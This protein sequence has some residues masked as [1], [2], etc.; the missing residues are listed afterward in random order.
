MAFSGDVAEPATSKA[1]KVSLADEAGAEIDD[2]NPL[3]VAIISGGSGGV[4]YTEGDTDATII[5]NAILWEDAAN[6]LVVVSASKPLPV[7]LGTNNDV[8]ITSGTVTANAGTNLNTSLL[9]LET[10]G[11]LTT[12]A[13]KD[14]ATQTTLSAIN[15]KMVSG[16]DIGDVTINNS[17]GVSAVNIQDGGNVITI[18]GTLTSVATITNVVHVDDNS[19]SIS[20]DDGAGAIT[21]DNA[22]TFAVQATLSAETTKVIGTVNQGT[23]PW[24]VSGAVTNAVLSVVG[25]G[26]EATAQ[27]VTIATDSTG[28]LSIDDNGSSITVDG[29]VAL[30]VSQISASCETGTVYQGTTAKTPATLFANVAASQTDSVLLAAQGASNKIRVLQVA[31]VAGSTATNLTFNSKGAGAGTA[32]SPL[33]ANAANGGEVLPFSPVGWFDTVANEALTVTTG[34]GSTTGILVKYVVVT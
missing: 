8:T 28:V 17:S 4:Q 21:V 24:V 33:F 6:T 5:G 34:A 26:T 16:T 10:G 31:V 30:S 1:R 12:I 32:I 29:T 15:N 18:D 2:A 7:D 14:F 22:G 25:S 27:R 13:G 11:N 23:S 19:S 9:A 20:I 3:P